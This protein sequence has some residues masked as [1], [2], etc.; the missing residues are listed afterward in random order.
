MPLFFHFS[1]FVWKS[2]ILIL[3]F[4]KSSGV[5]V[6]CAY[7]WSNV[8]GLRKDAFFV[9]F[10][11]KIYIRIYLKI[12]TYLNFSFSSTSSSSW[13]LKP[14]NFSIS[15]SKKMYFDLVQGVIFLFLKLKFC[16]GIIIG[17]KLLLF[18]EDL[19]SFWVE[20]I[21]KDW[22]I[23]LSYTYLIFL[24]FEMQDYRGFSTSVSIHIF[25]R[26]G[27]WQK[28]I[29][30]IKPYNLRIVSN[31]DQKILKVQ[32]FKKSKPLRVVLDSKGLKIN[33]TQQKLKLLLSYLH[34]D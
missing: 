11:F 23:L 17:W 25:V 18:V 13:L 9:G 14:Q 32:H 29:C 33:L 20:E 26:N 27:I 2:R 7:E 22:R 8:K 4:P 28:Y 30:D 10:V 16:V 24:G 31:L 5:V 21:F 6:E 34:F 12:F 3:G 19:K 15:F 1:I